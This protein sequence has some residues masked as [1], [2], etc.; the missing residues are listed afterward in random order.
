PDVQGV[1]AYND[2]S[3]LGAIAAAKQ[4]NV[5]V[6]F[7]S[8]NGTADA[9]GA[10]LAGDLLA[11]CDIQPIELGRTLGKAIVDHLKGITTLSGSTQIAAPDSAACLI[12]ADNAADW[13][14][15]EEKLTYQTIP[16]G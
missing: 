12:T 1:F 8:R 9:V 4:A 6:L 7:S 3:A 14:P 10:V 16:L 2:D 13:K 11:T 15:Y 5:S